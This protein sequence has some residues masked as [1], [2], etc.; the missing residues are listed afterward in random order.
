MDF[1]WIKL[2][3]LIIQIYSILGGLYKD[4]KSA[5]AMALFKF[6]QVL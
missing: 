5:P 3:L 1:N 6:F 4:E 2:I